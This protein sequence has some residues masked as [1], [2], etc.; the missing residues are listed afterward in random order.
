MSLY[1]ARCGFSPGSEQLNGAGGSE[2]AALAAL[3]EAQAAARAAVRDWNK[4]T[5]PLGVIGEAAQGAPA[6]VQEDGAANEPDDE[7]SNAEDVDAQ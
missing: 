6:D 5:T 3:E 1:L 7:M 2:E 4:S